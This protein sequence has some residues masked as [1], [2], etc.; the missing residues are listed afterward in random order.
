MTKLDEI[1]ARVDAA[2]PGPWIGFPN[3]I[4]G[5]VA[6]QPTLHSVDSLEERVCPCCGQ[7]DGSVVIADDFRMKFDADFVAHARDDI[8]LL[9]R[10]VRQLSAVRL[11]LIERAPKLVDNLPIGVDRDVLELLYDK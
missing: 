4:K 7:T 10:A 8:P 3:A 11:K 6:F 2:T 9:I 1:E 5:G